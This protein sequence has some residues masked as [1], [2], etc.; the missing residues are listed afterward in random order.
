MCTFI[1]FSKTDSLLFDTDCSVLAALPLLP[2]FVSC[3][4]LDSVEVAPPRCFS[5]ST[6]GIISLVEPQQNNLPSFQHVAVPD[7]D[8]A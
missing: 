5:E 3:S 6:V 1:I 2:V 4:A 7:E 8:E